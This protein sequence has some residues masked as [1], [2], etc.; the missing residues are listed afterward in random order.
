MTD[1]DW[2][3]L[4]KQLRVLVDIYCEM[5]NDVI[6]I[7]SSLKSIV[8]HLRGLDNERR[9]RNRKDAHPSEPPEL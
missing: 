3:N 9:K 4:R 5:N 7:K 1:L 2:E 8:K 6:K